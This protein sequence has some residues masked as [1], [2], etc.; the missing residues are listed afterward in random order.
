MFNYA[1]QDDLRIITLA[2]IDYHRLSSGLEPPT[3]RYISRIQ[4]GLTHLSLIHKFNFSP[5]ENPIAPRSES[6]LVKALR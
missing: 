4:Y 2:D 1:Q 5:P 3:S 6:K